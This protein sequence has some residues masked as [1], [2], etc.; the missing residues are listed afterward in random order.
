MRKTLPT[1]VTP[2]KASQENVTS[3]PGLMFPMSASFTETQTCIFAK[4]FATRKM[5]E[6]AWLETTVWP[7]LTRRSMMTPSIGAVMVQ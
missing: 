6:A 5:L 2:G 3:M 4:S 7:M 1:K